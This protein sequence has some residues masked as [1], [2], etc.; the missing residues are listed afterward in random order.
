MLLGLINDVL[1]FSK[2]EAGKMTILDVPYKTAPM[3]NDLVQLLNERT[4]AK[5]LKSGY[6]IARDITKEL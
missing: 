5:S 2:I 6:D 4:I 3:I 1:D